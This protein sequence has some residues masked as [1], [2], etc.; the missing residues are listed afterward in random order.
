MHWTT[1]RHSVVSSMVFPSKPISSSLSS[2]DRFPGLVKQRKSLE[3]NERKIRPSQNAS[4]LVIMLS[5]NTT[6]YWQLWNVNY[7]LEDS[8]GNHGVSIGKLSWDSISKG[9]ILFFM[10]E[11]SMKQGTLPAKF[12]KSRWPVTASIH[13]SS[14]RFISETFAGPIARDLN[15]RTLSRD[16][17]MYSRISAWSACGN[18]RTKW[19]SDLQ[20]CTSNMISL[21]V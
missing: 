12:I 4:S 8:R 6:A 16:S 10:Q 20:P 17:C 18:W 21:P 9:T 3:K 1:I 19:I 13:Y 5:F 7:Q 14:D 2:K 11:T 15:N